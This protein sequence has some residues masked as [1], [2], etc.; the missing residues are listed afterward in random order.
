M[1]L[2]AKSLLLKYFSFNFT[3]HL[4]MKSYATLKLAT[5]CLSVLLLNVSC[6]STNNDFQ[7]E[8]FWTRE[9]TLA[10]PGQ[11]EVYTSGGNI[12]VSSHEEDRVRVEMRVR[13]KGQEIDSIEAASGDLLKNYKINISNTGNTVV[14]R[15]ESTKTNWFGFNNTSI[16]FRVYVPRAM[17]CKLNTSGG[18]ISIAGVNGE[19]EIHTSGGNLNIETIEGTMKASTSGGTIRVAEFAGALDAGTSGG[20]IAL[21]NA[22]GNLEVSTS[23]GSISLQNVSGTIDASTSGGSITANVLSLG[24][25]LTLNT[26]GGSIHAVLPGGL[27]LDL[28]LKGNKVNTTL[29]NFDG[30]VEKDKVRGK[31]NGGG[32][33]VTLSTSGGSIT[34]DYQ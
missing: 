1:H 29:S 21:E 20:S 23:G 30:E 32:I 25:Q 9:F 12:E 33:P 13:V 7:S 24:N 14:A 2:T 6:A 28:N 4:A 5:L 34:L 17:S 18:T 19:Q 11:L 31:L 10:T 8:P 27:G 16:S 22:S 15:A 3:L 26:S